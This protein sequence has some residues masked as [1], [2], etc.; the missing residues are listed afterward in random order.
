[1]FAEL[2]RVLEA[3]EATTKRLV[4]ID[5]LTEFFA[6]LMRQHRDDLVP[7]VYLC[8]CRVRRM[9]VQDDGG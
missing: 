6:R 3:V 8:L 5:I 2:C 7:A 1:M 9:A 4:I